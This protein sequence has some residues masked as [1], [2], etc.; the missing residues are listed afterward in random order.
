MT[1]ASQVMQ[2]AYSC[3]S[4][5]VSSVQQGISYLHGAFTMLLRSFDTLDD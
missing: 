3:F 4:D 2:A 1:I 5:F